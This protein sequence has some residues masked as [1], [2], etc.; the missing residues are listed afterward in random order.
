MFTDESTFTVRSIK[1]RLRVWRKPGHSWEQQCTVPTF[2]SGFQSVSVWGGFSKQGR[3]CLVGIVENFNQHTYRSIIDA[4]ILPFKN[5]VHANTALF[6]LQEDNCGPHRA[7]S[8]N[9]YMYSASVNRMQGPA[10]SPDL[11]PIE[12]MWGI[13]KQNLRKRI[14]V[15]SNPTVVSEFLPF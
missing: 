11:N 1:N 6:T 12:N 10:Q 15:P 4:H 3:T 14:V 5:I 8:V 2:K 13:M 9:T 7:K